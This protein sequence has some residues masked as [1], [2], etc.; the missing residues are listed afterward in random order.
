M[1]TN[2][3]FEF[4][5]GSP[6]FCLVDTLGD[7]GGPGVERLAVPADL[8][9]WLRAAGLLAAGDAGAGTGQLREARALREA[10]HRCGLRAIAGRAFAAA[11]TATINRAAARPPLRPQLGRNGWR[12]VARRPVEAALSALAADAIAVLGSDRRARI[13]CCPQCAMMFIDTSRPGKRRWCS[14]ARGCG[15]RAKVRRLRARRAGAPADGR[16]T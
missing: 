5:A 9:A 13:R 14:S 1:T 2:P 3:R 16:T 4:I 10:I 15:N 7:R 12:Y 8:D 6:A 11:D